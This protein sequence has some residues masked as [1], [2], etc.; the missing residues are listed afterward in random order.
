MTTD[1]RATVNWLRDAFDDRPLVE[2]NGRKF[3]INPLTEQVPATS[4]E[5]LMAAAWQIASAG[6]FGSA[7]TIAGEEDKGGILVAAVS[8]VTGLPFGL[9]RW[10]PSGLQGQ[11][12]VEFASEYSDGRIY[13]NGVDPGDEVVIVDDLI[14]TGGTMIALIR[15]IEQ[16]GARIR[17]II[18]V[19]EKV[20][21]EGRQ[22]VKDATGH[23]MKCLLQL[24]VTGSRCKVL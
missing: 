12:S 20:E 13:L 21:Y 19:A 8:M 15:A 11:V 22:R 16:S 17:D 2:I 1:Q 7:C 23:D 6:D 14:S 9:A 24:S 4:A 10:Y 18:C 5:L 3:V